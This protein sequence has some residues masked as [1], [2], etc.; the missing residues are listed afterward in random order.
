[1][2]AALLTNKGGRENNEDYIRRATSGDIKCFVVADGLGGHKCGEVASEIVAETIVEKFAE[3]PE[4]SENA[5]R[6]YLTEAV[7]VLEINRNCNEE[8][9]NMATTVVVLVTDGK[10]AVWAHIGDSRLYRL[11]KKKIYEITSDHSAA[12]VS[13]ELGDIEFDDIRTSPDQS[14]L[15]KSMSTVEKFRPEISPV[16]KIDKHTSFLLCT[17]GFWEYVYEDEIEKAL[18][19]AEGPGEW[20]AKMEKILVAR[21]ENMENDNYSAIAVINNL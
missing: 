15:L 6:S 21:T 12:F 10:T 16:I 20:L 18:R 1:M 14:R 2:V 5:I 9:K 3:N 19:R 8:R 13:Y 4:I 17:D 11:R 7:K